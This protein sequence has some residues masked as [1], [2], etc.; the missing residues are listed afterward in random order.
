MTVASAEPTV[1]VAGRNRRRRRG[2]LVALAALVVLLLLSLA[3]G[4]KPLPLDVVLGALTGDGGEAHAIVV[5]QRIPRTV[6]AVLVGAAL[7]VAGALMQGLTRNPLADPG[8]LGVSSGAALGVVTAVLV[9]PAAGQ[10]TQ[11]S[12]AF[13]GAVI[14]TV[15]VYGIGVATGRGSSPVTLILAGVALG[16]VMQGI[17]QSFVLL[18]ADVF[19]TMRSWQAGSVADLGWDPVKVLAPMLA[20]GLALALFSAR[21]LN[22]V[23]L[24]DD[25]ATALGSNRQLTRVLVVLA[26]TVLC[27]SATAVAGVVWFLGMMVGFMARWSVGPD[28]RWIVAYCCLYG[29]VV[30]VA[31]DVL[32]R[33]VVI[34]NEIPAGVVSGVVGA[35]VL[36]ALVRR[37]K[38]R[39]L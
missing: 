5:E 8:L 11:V 3:F 6:I 13:V 33:V 29:P 12:A 4:S 34:P 35:P 24:G 7:A 25:L 38:A 37:S 26:V 21:G 10:L 31:A 16:A 1:T 9:L 27:G 2:L 22:A 30:M 36:I 20:V 17:S 15:V 28:H 23:G 32:G 14:T 19:V 18:N 39:G